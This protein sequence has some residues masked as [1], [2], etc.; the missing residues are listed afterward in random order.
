MNDIIN[1]VSLVGSAFTATIVYC[2]FQL[3]NFIILSY[4]SNR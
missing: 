1:K 4:Y 3:L 2:I